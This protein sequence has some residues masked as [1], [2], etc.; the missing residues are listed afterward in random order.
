[1]RNNRYCGRK[2]ISEVVVECNN[3]ETGR[4]IVK[5]KTSNSYEVVST[6]KVGNWQLETWLES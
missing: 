1:M 6:I 4:A 2:K 3:N 5:I